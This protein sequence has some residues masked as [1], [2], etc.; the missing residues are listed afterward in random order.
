MLPKAFFLNES[1]YSSSVSGFSQANN[2]PWPTSHRNTKKNFCKYVVSHNWHDFLRLGGR[3]NDLKFHW[4]QCTFF[5][6]TQVSVPS[7]TAHVLHNHTGIWNWFLTNRRNGGN[8]PLPP[9]QLMVRAQARSVPSNPARLNGRV[10]HNEPVS[11][12]AQGRRLCNALAL[13]LHVSIAL[14]I[15]SVVPMYIAI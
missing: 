15:C 1:F 9:A 12:L 5:T 7:G 11:S 4:G 13:H 8:G 14:F 2:E 3:K 6:I 10:L